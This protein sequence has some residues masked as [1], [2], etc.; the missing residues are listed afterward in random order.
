[1]RVAAPQ[2]VGP[3]LQHRDSVPRHPEGKLWGA[4]WAVVEDLP[5]IPPTP[6]PNSPPTLYPD[7]TLQKTI[8]LKV[9]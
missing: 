2:A 7:L 5:K 6:L 8:L 4:A 3:V 1:M 9:G